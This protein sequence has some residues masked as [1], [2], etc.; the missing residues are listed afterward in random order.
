MATF[1]VICH[2]RGPAAAPSSRIRDTPDRQAY[3]L[4]LLG[5]CPQSLS[6]FHSIGQIDSDG[7][8]IFFIPVF[9]QAFL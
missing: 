1:S 7:H 4:H 5:C 6:F 2:W 3:Y 8:K 9:C